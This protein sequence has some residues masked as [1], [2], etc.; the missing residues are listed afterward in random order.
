MNKKK[1]LGD[2]SRAIL[3]ARAKHPGKTIAWLY[4]P[5]TMPEN[6]LQAHQ[7]NDEYI[8]TCIYGKK[9]KDDTQRLER[10]FEM[11]AAMKEKIDQPLFSDQPMKTVKAIK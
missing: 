10:L 3:K 1:I 4:N 8:E 11:Y 7:E 5:E 6:L 9:F 2:H